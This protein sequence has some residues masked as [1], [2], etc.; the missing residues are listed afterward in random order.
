VTAR[1]PGFAASIVARGEG[2]EAVCVLPADG[3]V[4]VGDETFTPPWAP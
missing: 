3:P 4:T 1:P 2:A